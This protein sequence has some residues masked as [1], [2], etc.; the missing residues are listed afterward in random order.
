MKVCSKKKVSSHF[1]I[2]QLEKPCGHLMNH[3]LTA[4][5]SL[6]CQFLILFLLIPGMDKDKLGYGL[7]ASSRSQCDKSLSTVMPRPH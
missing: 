1:S 3:V 7:G 4:V 6:S 2:F 5:V